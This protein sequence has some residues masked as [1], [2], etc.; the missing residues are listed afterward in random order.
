MRLNRY[1]TPLLV[2]VAALVAGEALAQNMPER[3]LVRRGN[4]QF[5]KQHYTESIDLYE[6]ALVADPDSFE[7]QFNLATALSKNRRD[8]KPELAERAE[9]LL[10][11]LEKRTDL[12]DTQRADVAYNLG[13]V[14]FDGGNLQGALESYRN[15]MRFNPDDQ[16]AKFNYAYTKLLLQQ[17]QQQNEQNQQNQQNEQ[18]QD[19]Q[20]DKQDQQQDKQDQQQ[21]KQDQQQD[22]Q[23]QQQQQQDKQEQQQQQDKQEEQQQQQQ[24]SGISPQEQAA[25]LEAIQAQ[26]DKTQEKLKE[27]KGVLIRS[28]RNW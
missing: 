3:R 23:D 18:Q 4:R 15:A 16:D 14:R 9:K 26:E 11:G 25:M 5:D 12:D 8:D 19:Q 28:K 22:K 2:I 6:R 27:T 17:Q 13:N 7:A 20:Q 1:I 10:S 24:Q 21:D